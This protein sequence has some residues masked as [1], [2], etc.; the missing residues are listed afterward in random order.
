MSLVIVFFSLQSPNYCWCYSDLKTETLP[1]HIW[2]NHK[3]EGQ[4]TWSCKVIT[5]A[6]PI[7]QWQQRHESSPCAST[8]GTNYLSHNPHSDLG[9]CYSSFTQ[10]VL[11][12]GH[13]LA[14]GNADA[15]RTWMS[16]F[17]FWH[18]HQSTVSLSHS[19][20]F[21]SLKYHAFHMLFLYLECRI[22]FSGKFLFF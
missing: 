16:R 3:D 14:K 20:S 21:Y 17:T 19:E 11:F 4:S 22:V 13:W 9:Y 1:F 10:T 5:S 6:P 15:R 8:D 12:W 7:P 18:F 2:K